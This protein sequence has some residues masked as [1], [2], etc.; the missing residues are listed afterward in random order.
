MSFLFEKGVGA[1][2]GGGAGTSLCGLS[3]DVLLDRV[4]LLASLPLTGYGILGES[5]LTGSEPV[6]K[7][8]RLHDCCR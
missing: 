8:V 6:L 3:R 1:G 7:W 5:V 2:G 4:W